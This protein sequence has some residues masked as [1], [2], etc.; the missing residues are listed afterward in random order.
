MLEMICRLGSNLVLFTHLTISTYIRYKLF[1]VMSLEYAWKLFQR[2]WTFSLSV[3][4]LDRIF[5]CLQGSRLSFGV[6][7]RFTKDKVVSNDSAILDNNHDR[8]EYA[9]L[10]SQTIRLFRL[11]PGRENDPIRGRLF[12]HH[13]YSPTEYEALSYV[14]GDPKLTSNIFVR[15]S[16]LPITR[17]LEAALRSLRLEEGSRLLWID[18]ICINQDDIAERTHQVQM[19]ARIYNF[20]RNVVVWLG[21]AGVHSEIGVKTLQWFFSPMELRYN[22]P[23][24]SE[25][26]FLVAAG[27]RDILERPWFRRMWVVQEAALSQRATLTCGPHTLSWTNGVLST[28]NFMN[29]I[30]FAVISPQW[31]RARLQD[32]DMDPLL[33][34]LDLQVGQMLDKRRHGSSLRGPQ[35]LVDHAYTMRD[36][37][38]ADPR[39]KIF[40]LVGLSEDDSLLAFFKV[41]YYMSVDETYQ[42]LWD[43]IRIDR[44]DVYPYKVHSYY[45]LFSVELRIARASHAT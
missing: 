44:G 38:C 23:W 26:P 13:V 7:I 32:I 28:Q 29:M 14:W 27:L 40:A 10:K 8:Y 30:K 34:L 15:D 20:A 1:L 36:K 3:F 9:P 31:L 11:E 35:N 42:K 33:Q 6:W 5:H 4:Y 19:M 2:S 17:N 24:E 18:A 37:L 16:V 41:N 22:P 45:S 21:P 43:S 39:D 12:L 25:P